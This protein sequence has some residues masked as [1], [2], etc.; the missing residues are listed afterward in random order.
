MREPFAVWMQGGVSFAAGKIGVMTA[1]Q[2]MLSKG[3][4]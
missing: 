3:L 2:T 4:L 1:A